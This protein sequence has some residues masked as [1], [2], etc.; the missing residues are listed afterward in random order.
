MNK[1]NYFCLTVTIGC[2]FVS[3]GQQ[4]LSEREFQKI[5]QIQAQNAEKILETHKLSLKSVSI[6]TAKR[7]YLMFHRGIALEDWLEMIEKTYE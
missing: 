5:K 3:I 4:I 1:L 2:I 7:S 6:E